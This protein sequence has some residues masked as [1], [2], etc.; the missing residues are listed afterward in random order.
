MLEDIEGNM[1]TVETTSQEMYSAIM[2]GYG[3]K[4]AEISEICQSPP[5]LK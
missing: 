2:S 3:E 1:D 5:E 4:L